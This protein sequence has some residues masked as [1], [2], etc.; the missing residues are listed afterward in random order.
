MNIVGQDVS[1]NEGTEFGLLCTIVSL[2][3]GAIEEAKKAERK[4]CCMVVS[5]MGKQH[6]INKYKEAKG[7]ADEALLL[8][9]AAFRYSAYLDHLGFEGKNERAM[10]YYYQSYLDIEKADVA[11]QC[12]QDA[13]EKMGDVVEKVIKDNQYENKS[14]RAIW[15]NLGAKIPVCNITQGLDIYNSYR[16]WNDFAIE[17][18]RTVE[19]V[20][21]EA[22]AEREAMLAKI[23]AMETAEAMAI[24]G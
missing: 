22:R 6:Y 15:E 13:V 4:A 21:A 19:E 10:M 24:A 23:D 11:S 5:G 20:N 14:A 17:T 3:E 18:N 12:A 7:H 2:V 16:D 1:V 8:V 9:A